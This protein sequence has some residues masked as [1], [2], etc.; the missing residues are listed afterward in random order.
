MTLEVTTWHLEMRSPG[1]LRPGLVDSPDIRVSQVNPPDP[2]LNH[3]LFMEI[4]T[5]YHWFSRLSWTIDEWEQ[6][7]SSPD[8]QTWIGYVGGSPFG[9]FELQR[10]GETAEIMF[11]GLLQR[12]LGKGLGGHLLTTALQAAWQTPGTERIY[13]HTCTSDHERALANYRARGFTV[14]REEMSTESTPEPNDPV[15]SSTAY[16]DSL[17]AR[18]QGRAPTVTSRR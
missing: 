3:A 2:Q 5:P 9:Y 8:V 15:W 11:F 13:V 7:V 16:Y 1:D 17:R 18:T 6:Y 14:V 4:G 12:H 10:R